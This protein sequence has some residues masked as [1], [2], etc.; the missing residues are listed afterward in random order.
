MAGQLLLHQEIMLLAIRD[1]N[2]TFPGGMFLYSVAGAMVSEL[3]MRQRIVA[4]DDKTQIVTVIDDSPIGDFVLDEL[5]HLIGE[6]KKAKSLQHWV[7]M[8]ASI[9]KLKHLIAL[10]LCDLGI[11]KHDEKKMLWLF[12]QQIYP[13][14][15]G[16]YEDAIRQNMSKVMFD[17]KAKPD[18]PTAVLI[19]LASHA[20]LLQA[21]FVKEELRQHKDRIKQLANGDILASGVTQA[22]IQA[23]Q[24]AIVIAATIP[25]MTAAITA[26]H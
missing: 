16:S 12:T 26:S 3:L 2:G 18:G 6:S 24:T 14:L 5:L 21:N 1:D 9:P 7:F 10:Q 17:E 11:L 23:V 8:A 13:E 4:S 15:D 25:A 20:G 22:T 19:A